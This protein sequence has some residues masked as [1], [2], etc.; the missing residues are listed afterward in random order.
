MG[1]L[2]LIRRREVRQSQAH[3]LCSM[4]ALASMPWCANPLLRRAI[5]HSAALDADPRPPFPQPISGNEI[6]Q[7]YDICE[8]NRTR[9]FSHDF[10]LLGVGLLSVLSAELNVVSMYT[11]SIIDGNKAH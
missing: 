5:V 2:C 6:L 9:E 11:T 10:V 1:A 7:S 4:T 8:G 3:A